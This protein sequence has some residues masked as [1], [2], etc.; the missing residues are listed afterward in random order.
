MD[1]LLEG[2]RGGD[3]EDLVLPLISVDEYE[4]KIDDDSIVVAF[5]VSEHGA[6]EDLNRYLQRSP[7]ELLDTEISPAPDAQG[8]FMVFVELLRNKTFS[9]NVTA[10]LEEVAPLTNID[11][12]KMQVRGQDD[13][14]PFDEQTLRKIVDPENA[15]LAESIYAFLKPSDLTD[16]LVDEG[17]I[18]I[19]GGHRTHTFEIIAFGEDAMS[20]A[21]LM[22]SAVS[23]KLDHVATSHHLATLLGAGWSVAFIGGHNVVQHCEHRDTLILKA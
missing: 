17:M 16:A 3:L 8:Y 6:A 7:I 20:Q 10:L 22:E 18:R 12:W 4:S 2:M 13:L 9:E 21:G 19:S 11:N 5:Y 1:Q 15:A 23:M 14:I